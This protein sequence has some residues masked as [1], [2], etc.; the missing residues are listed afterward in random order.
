M[1]LPSDLP[2]SQK[3]WKEPEDEA[4]R[5][6]EQNG[7]QFLHKEFHHEQSSPPGYE[8]SIKISENRN[9]SFNRSIELHKLVVKPIETFTTRNVN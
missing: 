5:Y 6:D 1:F 7:E 9:K 8:S 4:E 2:F 3:K